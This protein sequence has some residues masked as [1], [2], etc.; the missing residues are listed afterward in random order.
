MLDFDILI[1]V[2]S[3]LNMTKAKR[4]QELMN[5]H[6]FSDARPSTFFISFP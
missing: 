1:S 6:M 5:N 2:W 3:T 4:V